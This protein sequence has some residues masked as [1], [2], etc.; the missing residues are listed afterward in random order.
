MY[1][2]LFV[3]QIQKKIYI[4]YFSSINTLFSL[5]YFVRINVN[6]YMDHSIYRSD[7]SQINVFNG[8][9]WD[10]SCNLF[11]CQLGVFK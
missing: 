6:L 2:C 4:S 9:E 7:G 1:V 3:L 11:N 8:G 10:Y 5:F